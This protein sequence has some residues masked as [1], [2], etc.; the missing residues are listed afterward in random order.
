MT[1][2]FAVRTGLGLAG[3][4]LLVGISMGAYGFNR[5][6]ERADCPGKM[7][8]PITGE[9]VCRDQCP[10]VDANRLDCPGK[11]E[12][13]LTGELVCG[14]ECPLGAASGTASDLP[15]CCRSSK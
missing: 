12:C 13:P 2:K 14:D 7:V 6:G 10:L 5:A 15:P 1:K 11:I 4:M 3:L 9:Q 8:C